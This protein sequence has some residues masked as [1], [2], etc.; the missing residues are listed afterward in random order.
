MTKAKQQTEQQKAIAAVYELL[1]TRAIHP[2]GKFDKGGRW[3]PCE[4]NADL[5][6]HIRSPSRSWPYS[7]L[8]ACRSKK[9]VKAVAEKY[10]A[11]TVEELKAKI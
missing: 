10:N 5:V 8:K 1:K 9:F 11:Q 4:A 6:G 2:S 3:F 7:Y